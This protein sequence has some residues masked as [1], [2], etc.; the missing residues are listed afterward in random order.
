MTI[1]NFRILLILCFLIIL[2]L[3]QQMRIYIRF[4]LPTCQHLVRSF[5]QKKNWRI[6]FIETAKLIVLATCIF[7]TIPNV[8]FACGGGFFS[9]AFKH[10]TIDIQIFQI[11]Y[12]SVAGCLTAATGSW[13]TASLGFWQAWGGGPVPTANGTNKNKTR[14]KR[15]TQ[16]QS[17]KNMRCSLIVFRWLVS[18]QM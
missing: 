13:H 15:T 11:I 2:C 18:Y 10:W 14:I 9:T 5:L 8:N 6:F 17:S 3:R 1:C 16:T 4:D 12:M 7:L